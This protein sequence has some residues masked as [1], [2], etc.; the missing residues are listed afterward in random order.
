MS[1]L[2]FTLKEI[3]KQKILYKGI[4]YQV[5]SYCN[6]TIYGILLK[7]LETNM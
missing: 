7:N 3:G 6:T 5:D 1:T 2:L 4:A